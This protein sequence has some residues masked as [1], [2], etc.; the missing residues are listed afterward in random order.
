MNKIINLITLAAI[1]IAILSII[2]SQAKAQSLDSM[3]VDLKNKGD[4]LK[5]EIANTDLKGTGKVQG[6]INKVYGYEGSVSAM[7]G[8]TW[9]YLHEVQDALL[10]KIK[11]TGQSGFTVAELAAID[12]FANGVTQSKQEHPSSNVFG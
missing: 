2:A 7:G 5:T 1:V 8:G 6:L 3:V 11:A 10:A 9:T 4:A 12:F